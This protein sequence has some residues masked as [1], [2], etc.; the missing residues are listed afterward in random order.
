MEQPGLDPAAPHLPQ[1][2]ACIANARTSN[3][4]ALRDPGI[5][6]VH[7][8]VLHAID[9]TGLVHAAILRLQALILPV[10]TLVPSGGH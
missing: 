3:Q 9:A 5:G 4:D 8:F 2:R 7:A 10:R 1:R 6:A